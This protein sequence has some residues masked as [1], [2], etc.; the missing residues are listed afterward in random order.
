MKVD[1]NEVKATLLEIK[2]AVLLFSGLVEMTKVNTQKQFLAIT[3][4]QGK[5]FAEIFIKRIIGFLGLQFGE[6]EEKVRSIFKEFQRGTRTIQ[7]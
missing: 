2:L 3:L 6:N 4:K 5:A 1:E 7:V